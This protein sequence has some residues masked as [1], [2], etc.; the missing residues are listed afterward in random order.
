MSFSEAYVRSTAPTSN[1]N[2]ASSST[3]TIAASTCNSA[4]LERAWCGK[5]VFS[6]H[7]ACRRYRFDATGD[8]SGHRTFERAS[9]VWARSFDKR[10]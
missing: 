9:R 6:F 4:R 2:G 3:R 7:K 8:A 10:T 5:A 1:Q